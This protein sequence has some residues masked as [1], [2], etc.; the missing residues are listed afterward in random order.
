MRCKISFAKSHLKSFE[1]ERGV[2]LMKA[3]LEADRPVASSCGGEGVCGKCRVTV[4]TGADQ[5][6]APNDLEL[7][8]RERENLGPQERIS[9]QCVLLGDVQLDT[10]YW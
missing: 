4:V 2:N 5:L 7:F 9:C 10:K 8:L 6:G 3:L 1:A